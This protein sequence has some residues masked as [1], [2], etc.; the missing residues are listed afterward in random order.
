LQLILS[1][2]QDLRGR[3]CV[4]GH[5]FLLNLLLLDSTRLS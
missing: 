3:L 1:I 4:F 5:S 2:K